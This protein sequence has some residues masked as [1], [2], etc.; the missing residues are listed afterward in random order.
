MELY[1]SDRFFSSGTTDIMNGQGE[2]LGTVD[3]QSMMTATLSVYGAGSALRYSGKFRFMSGKWEVSDASGIEVGVLRARFSLFSKKFEYDAGHRGLYAIESP[4]FSRE[5][6]ILD[7]GGR[8]V[9]T[10]ER[11][12]GWLQAGAFRL[13]NSSPSL[14]SY[15]L[16]AV[17]LGVHNIQK[18]QN[19]AAAST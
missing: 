17:V 13:A 19:N 6:A 1:F 14:D 10:F 15:E 4:A 3:L 16:I 12:S 2:P 9:A 7:E 5:Y 8:S 11:I 18:R